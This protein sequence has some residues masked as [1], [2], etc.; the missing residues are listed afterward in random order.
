MVLVLSIE[1]SLKINHLDG[2]ENAP[3]F[4]QV[5]GIRSLFDSRTSYSSL[6]YP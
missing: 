3:G 1:V 2:V 5:R 4:G 6:H